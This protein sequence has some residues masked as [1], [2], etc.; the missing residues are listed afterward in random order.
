MAGSLVT[1]VDA[2]VDSPSVI[3]MVLIA[4]PGFLAVL[5]S[6]REMLFTTSMPSMTL[7]LEL[8]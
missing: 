7:P 5:G 4:S 6:L 3:T 2:D 8:V 1:G